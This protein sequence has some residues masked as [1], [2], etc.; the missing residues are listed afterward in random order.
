MLYQL[1]PG[2]IAYM[3]NMYWWVSNCL[4]AIKIRLHA[5]II[6]TC[7][8]FYVFII[9]VN[10][11]VQLCRVPEQTLLE[12][13]SLLLTE[14]HMRIKNT[15]KAHTLELIKALVSVVLMAYS[16]CTVH[17]S[18]A[19]KSSGKSE[20]EIFDQLMLLLDCWISSKDVMGCDIFGGK[21]NTLFS[22]WRGK[23]EL[24]V[25]KKYLNQYTFMLNCY[26]SFGRK[27]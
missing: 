24:K 3:S 8:H 19:S 7:I 17:S 14:V 2:T 10:C 21:G 16:K 20:G 1:I 26:V 4:H 18:E 13:C 9:A 15:Q 25:N 12:A 6:I 5:H 22:S 11:N 27:S 23:D